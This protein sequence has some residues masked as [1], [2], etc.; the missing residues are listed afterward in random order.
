[1]R[2]R[3]YIEGQNIVIEYRFGGEG[4]DLVGDLAAELVRLKVDI[5]V[6]VSGPAVRAAKAATGTIPIVAHD[7]QTD[8]VRA[9]L[10]ASLARPGGNLT[11]FFLDLAELGGKHVEL[12]K[13][14]VPGLSRV[15]ALWP[16]ASSQYPLGAA[17]AAARS[18]EVHLQV[19]EVRGPDDFEKAFEAATRGR[20][21]ALIVFASP[22][23]FS[24]RAEIV[25][26]AA[27][28]RL[29][30]ISPLDAF[31]ESGALMTYGPN[32]LA[33]FRRLGYFVDKLVKGAKPGD[34]PV[35]RPTQFELLINMKTA[36]ALGMTVPRSILQR[37]DRVIE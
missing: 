19:L 35:E 37:A 11:G 2:E 20:A 23:F 33:T 16:A 29:P 13:E 10:V 30:T 28:G 14:V 27:K 25:G 6:P 1:L 18:L 21:Q 22:I 8:P 9:G 17:E 15:A 4:T 5:L 31:A 36:K 34:V 7:L 32:L 12:L 26:R 3:G 24:H